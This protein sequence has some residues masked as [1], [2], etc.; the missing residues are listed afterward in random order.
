ML[1]T[2]KEAAEML[3]VSRSWFRTGG[4]AELARRG[5]RPPFA[6][7]GK[8]IRYRDEDLQDWIE[9]KTVTPKD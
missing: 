5:E 1:L 6:K 8:L 9:A 7:L 3:G 2:D 4:R